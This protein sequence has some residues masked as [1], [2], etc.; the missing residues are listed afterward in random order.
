MTIQEINERRH[1]GDMLNIHKLS[2]IP[3][4][5]IQ[6]V[7]YGKVRPTSRR[8]KEVIAWFEKFYTAID[9]LTA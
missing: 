9:N 1:D 4:R 6:N 3:K 8:S 7:V 5:S 2:G